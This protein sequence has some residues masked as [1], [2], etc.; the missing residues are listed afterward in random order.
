MEVYY[1]IVDD[2]VDPNNN[3]LE[4]TIRNGTVYAISRTHYYRKQIPAGGLEFMDLFRMSARLGA[5]MIW[6]AAQLSRP[7]HEGIAGPYVAELATLHGVDL[8]P[9]VE[10]LLQ[11]RRRSAFRPRLVDFE[12][13]PEDE[14]CYI[15]L[16][17]AEE[18]PE[19][20]WVIAEGCSRHRF[21][22]ECMLQWTGSNCMTCQA[23]LRSV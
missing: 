13:V 15:C 20:D 5:T 18:T 11:T 4:I 6:L 8:V 3:E 14:V 7:E 17:S 10:G 19:D 23:P 16:L 22:R 1:R 12:Y 2:E 9:V 21:H